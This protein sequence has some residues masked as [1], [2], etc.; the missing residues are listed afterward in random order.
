MNQTV[1]S[2]PD[3]T[4]VV[5]G[6]TGLVG[7]E[8]VQLLLEDPAYNRV[9][10]LVRRE[11][12]LTHPKLDE[13]QISFDRLEE[14]IDGAWL[15]DADVYCTLGTTIKK[16]GSQEVF[17][18]V[19]YT[20]PVELGHIAKRSGAARYLIVTAMGANARS[21]VF[22]SRVKGEVERDL[23]ALGLPRLVILQPSLLL[24]ERGERRPAEWLASVLARPLSALMVGP[25][26]KY[27]A[28]E[29]RDVARA[30]IATARKDGPSLEVLESDGIARLAASAE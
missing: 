3:L 28:I 8:L 16:A 12:G 21:K 6:A 9:I 23:T 2:T 29:G 20:Y 1:A 13:R 17:R 19:D 25:L 22:Y 5:A 4:A 10:A 15:R 27:K 11:L 18:R 14:E 26:A 7:R 24:G 30:M